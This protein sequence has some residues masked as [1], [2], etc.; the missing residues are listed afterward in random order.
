MIATVSTILGTMQLPGIPSLAFL[1]YLLFFL[2]WLA[3]RSASR[4]RQMRAGG[5]SQAT[6]SREGIWIRTALTQAILLFLA[7]RTGQSFDDHLFTTPGIGLRDLLLAALALAI[8][9]GFRRILRSV[10]S[11]SERR[12]SVVYW[13]APATDRETVLWAGAVLLASVAEEAAY[14]GV[15]MSILWYSLDNY[16][17]AAVVSAVAFAL[18]HWVQGWKSGVVIFAIAL[19]FQG[20][21]TLTGTLILA[22]I[23]HAVYDFAAGWS[24]MRE[25]KSAAP[26]G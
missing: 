16:W 13:I 12:G 15:G 4:V 10:R 23:V 5:A 25:A 19:V 18:A 2:P 3:I 14:R 8:C 21:V 7:L 11:E 6:V 17:M 22:M 24:I 20:L 9:F 26:A 1:F